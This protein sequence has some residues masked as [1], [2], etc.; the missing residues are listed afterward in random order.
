MGFPVVKRR[1]GECFF[2]KP[3]FVASTVHPRRQPPL[4]CYPPF[5]TLLPE[6]ASNEGDTWIRDYIAAMKSNLSI[7]GTMDRFDTAATIFHFSRVKSSWSPLLPTP[8]L[9]TTAGADDTF[10]L[11][12][13]G[14]TVPRIFISMPFIEYTLNVHLEM[15]III[16]NIN[17]SAFQWSTNVDCT[18]ARGCWKF[19]D[20]SFCS[21]INCLFFNIFKKGDLLIADVSIQGFHY[22]SALTF[23]CFSNLI[24]NWAH[25]TS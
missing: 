25:A 14:P 12:N 5:R 6:P 1:G 22:F 17:W 16:R 19:Y 10:L 18:S 13:T 9:P 4:S 7:H 2:S 23:Q 11:I 21:W 8:L 20:F 24:L 3:Q 15:F